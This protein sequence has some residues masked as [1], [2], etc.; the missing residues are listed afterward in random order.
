MSTTLTAGD[1]A[2]TGYRSDTP[3]LY[4]FVL[5]R[6]IEAGTEI[7]FTDNGWLAAGGFREGEDTITWTADTA[8]T[9]GTVVTIE[10]GVATSGTA[11]GNL[12]LSSAG[13]QVF[14]FQGDAANP[15]FIYGLHGDGSFEA[16]ATSSSTSALPPTLTEGE[17]ALAI[18]PEADNAAYQGITSGTRT[19]L[20]AAIS[21]INNWTT[22]NTSSFSDVTP[23]SFT[24][25]DG[26]SVDP[27]NTAPVLLDNA[28][29]T[30]INEDITDAANTGNTVA[31]LASGLITD[32][33][34][35][36]QAIAITGVDN[37]N[38]TWQYS[39][40]GGSSWQDI[41]ASASDS[42]AVTLGAT[43]LYTPALGTAPSSQSW[44]SLTNLNLT[45]PSTTATE[46]VSGSGATLDTTADQN[47]YAGYSN[48]TLPSLVNANFPT[49]DN[50]VGYEISFE[51]QLLEESRTNENRA[52]FSLVAVSQDATKAIELGF[53]Q[54]SETT[55]NIFA[56]GG[57]TF[58]AAENVSF[59]TNEATSYTLA[60]QGDTYTLF[61]DG[62][63]ILTGALRDY[64]SFEGAIDPYETS[65]FIFLG[66]DTTSAQGSFLLSQ[67]AIE[68]ETRI[69]FVPNAEYT[70]DATIDF[71]AWD[72]TDGSANG[73]AGV[74]ASTNGNNTAFSST[75]STG[76][77]TVNPGSDGVNTVT[78]VTLGES[79]S[80]SSFAGVGA[81]DAPSEEIRTDA[82]TLAFSGEGLVAS[83]LL[84]TQQGANLLVSFAVANSP[85]V[86]LANFNL[87]DLDNLT[88]ESGILGNIRFDGQSTPSDDYDV[89]AADATPTVVA[90]ENTVTFLNDLN[91]SVA[92]L[93]NSD[94]INGQGGDDGLFG[95][96]GNDL[97]RGGDG[98]DTL[99]GGQGNDTLEGGDGNDTLEGKADDDQL[100]GG[101]NNDILDGADGND[102]LF[103]QLDSD[104]L[105]GGNGNDTLGGGQGDD[106]L[107]GSTGRDQLRGGLGNDTLGGG[108]GT[109]TLDGADGDDLLSG[110]RRA[111][112]LTGGAGSD[113]FRYTDFQQ[114]LLNDEGIN[115]FDTITDLVIG[116][117]IIDSL[118]TV[119]AANV[120]QT[121]EVA[122]L[123]EA[124][125]QAVLTTESFVADGA[126]TFTLGSRDFLALNDGTAGFQISSDAV[127][128]I[129]GYT[130]DLG[131]LAI[132]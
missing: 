67:V 55:G 80:L 127:I 95:R 118:T 10:E 84:L 8:L 96:L 69:R 42:N 29:F 90:R 110:G 124:G 63:Q 76:T 16:D 18:D 53:Q 88:L 23:S 105:F 61:A 112:I 26:G 73:E 72:T 85:E 94:V 87:E 98:N 12:I 111:D 41:D 86:L 115:N 64:T 52:G 54:T 114:S 17:T 33:D 79:P 75:F 132:A 45:T 40:D 66:D 123:D 2:I 125:V 35:D 28:T 24:V 91:N 47:I 37:T 89:I 56:Q 21:N 49:L 57:P 59:N 78:A 65:N 130:G 120:V 3:D 39:I 106:E 83:N 48:F 117:D 46:T 74:D 104:Q 6:D 9:A 30:S 38:G 1:I 58:E 68:T 13:D 11:T 101:N 50:T 122:T 32:A 31:E 22:S 36:P 81:S 51:M 34:F 102:N 107:F 129:T 70:G 128:E 60:V 14:A 4:A 93:N 109:D 108:R 62:A 44:L 113:T 77:I 100:A 7:Q 82:D 19:E 25:S 92:G 27:N 121:G 103:G 119:D 15:T 126:A 116:T 20:L 99:G 131:N 97:L 71:R 43:S 5:L